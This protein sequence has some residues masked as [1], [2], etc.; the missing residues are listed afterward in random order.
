MAVGPTI[1]GNYEDRYLLRATVL[2]F[3]GVSIGIVPNNR[4]R[5][6]ATKA[7]CANDMIMKVSIDSYL[8]HGYSLKIIRNR[9]SFE[10]YLITI[11]RYLLIIATSLELYRWIPTALLNRLARESIDT[12]C[13]TKLTC[14]GVDRH[15]LLS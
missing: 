7:Y 8:G 4:V 3:R 9:L 10:Q 14:K 12:Y 15:L 6:A 11:D 5:A 13:S 2:S 1:G